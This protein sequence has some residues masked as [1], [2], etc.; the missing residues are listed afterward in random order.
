MEEF[1]S[2]DNIYMSNSIDELV[3]ALK[4]VISSKK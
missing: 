1:Y 2:G 4:V 3:K